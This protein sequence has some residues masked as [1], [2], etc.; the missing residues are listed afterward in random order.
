MAL[1]GVRVVTGND[2]LLAEYRLDDGTAVPSDESDPGFV[3]QA[4]EGLRV[5]ELH[6]LMVGDIMQENGLELPTRPRTVK[7]SDGLMFLA[8]VLAKYG[9]GAGMRAEPL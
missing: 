8:G 3:D 1:D 2:K 9:Y 7:P 5:T 6:F 4:K